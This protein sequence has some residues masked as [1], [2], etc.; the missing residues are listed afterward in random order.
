MPQVIKLNVLV[1]IYLYHPLQ[2][3]NHFL[4]VA[5]RILH[6]SISFAKFF[7]ARVMLQFTLNVLP[8]SYLRL[9]SC[10]LVDVE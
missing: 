3:A 1:S 7:G 6:I 5:H 4:H 2:A 10:G 9:L 8:F